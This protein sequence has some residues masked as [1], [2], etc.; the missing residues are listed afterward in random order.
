MVQTG[1]RAQI[2]TRSKYHAADIL[3]RLLK[4][5]RRPASGQTVSAPLTGSALAPAKQREV[6]FADFESVAKLKERGG[7]AKDSLENWQRLWQQNPALVAA[8]SQ[9]SMGWVLETEQG[10]VGYQGNIP[11]LYQ[12]ESR[13]I[14]AAIAAGLVI[15]PSYRTRCIGLLASFFRQRDVDLFVITHSTASV[16]NQSKALHARSLPDPDYD[17]ILFWILD[18]HQFARALA[19]KFG[20]GSGMEAVGTFLASSALRLDS[21]RRGPRGRLMSKITEIDVKNIGDEFEALWRRKLREAPR[22]LAD[23]SP[24][25]LRWHF[26]LPGSSSTVAV[27]CCHRF[28]RLAGYAVVLHAVDRKTGLRRSM[29]ADI[30]VEQDDPDV[31]EALLD[32]AYSNAVASGGHLF[33]VVG[34]AGHIRRIMMS[35]KP[36]V[37]SYPT[38]P[39]VYKTT[40]QA[41]ARALADENAWYAGPFDGDAT[42]LP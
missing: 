14:I 16:V 22:L 17:K 23:R 1:T 18:V 28:Q 27:L 38:D 26:T 30:L 11:V 40:D 13:T 21:L 41:L 37:R 29:L 15:D 19:A 5:R 10:I 34:V 24:A 2:L 9:P 25:S 35:W 20:R 12:L 31:T 6:R 3:L 42:L 36:Y 8:K 4:S 32:A 39:L 7:L 33:E